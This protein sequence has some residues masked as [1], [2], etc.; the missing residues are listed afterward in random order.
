MRKI[1]I[2]VVLLLLTLFFTQSSVFAE[3]TDPYE[4][5][6]TPQTATQV[7]FPLDTNVKIDTA[8]DVDWFK[9][10][11]DREGALRFR[12][13]RP[14]YFYLYYDIYSEEE[15][16]KA[17]PTPLYSA[18]SG[19]SGSLQY[20]AKLAAGVY[21]LKLSRTDFS[22]DIMHLTMDLLPEDECENNDS[23]EQAYLFPLGEERAITINAA[24]EGNSEEYS[25]VDW[26]KVVLDRKG[27]LK[28]SI[29]N[30]V[31]IYLN[32]DIYPEEE[33]TK[34]N[35]IPIYSRYK[36]WAEPLHYNAKL[37]AG[38][39][40]LKLSSS[41]FKEEEMQLTLDLLPEDE[42]EN[43]DS[44]E[45]AY[46]F[47]LGEERAITINADS[48]DDSD[49]SN[50][51]DWFKVVLN[52]DGALKT[53]IENSQATYIDYDI[54]TEEELI[55]ENP[56]PIYTRSKPWPEPLHYNAKLKSGVY[57]LKLSSMSFNEKEMLL[58]ID[59]LAE[60]ECENNDSWQ[61]AYPFPLGETKL[62]T[63]N[64]DSEDDSDI[65]N[66]VD[67]FK[68]ELDRTGALSFSLGK[69][70]YYYDLNYEVY[71]DEELAKENPTPIYTKSDWD[72]SFYNNVK[73][74]SGVYY[75]KISS[76]DLIKDELQLTLDLLPEDECE[77]NDTW[78][79]AYP[80]PLGEERV[81]TINSENDTDWFM[82]SL[83]AYAPVRFKLENSG[84]TYIYLSYAI[85]DSQP[86]VNTTPIYQEDFSLS[87]NYNRL[88]SYAL[89]AGTYYIKLNSRNEDFSEDNLKLTIYSGDINVA[90]PQIDS[91]RPGDGWNNV[92]VFSNIEII[93]SKPI[94]QDTLNYEN[95]SLL[96][97]NDPVDFTIDYIEEENKLVLLPNE[98]LNYECQYNIILKDGIRAADNGFTL[99]K[100]Y[101]SSFNTR[102][103]RI[104]DE[105]NSSISGEVAVANNFAELLISA[106]VAARHRATNYTYYTGVDHYG[107]FAF[108]Y[109]PAGTYDVSLELPT[110]IKESQEVEIAA[111]AEV[112]LEF[113]PVFGDFNEDSI[114][115][116]YDLVYVSQF[117]S[118]EEN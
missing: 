24:S 11:L 86:D 15:V 18:R 43:N 91:I 74:E 114:V 1:S 100:D 69:L 79:N 27:A 110:F 47:P 35:P 93:F 102:E 12:I 68:V 9:V 40:Y 94:Q 65:Y 70:N 76:Q 33:L 4:N 106:E 84:S 115:D 72:T 48:E 63:I 56:T 39:Y 8:N 50:D 34:E 92:D 90:R 25:D 109:L 99:V 89:E 5:N 87:G 71:T 52:R 97:W 10:V 42:C 13:E 6:D 78:Q 7:V 32:Y 22:E 54:Y 16:I 103:K 113:D 116:L 111:F 2:I 73:L 55:K 26:F 57:Y 105:H 21:Y 46:L 45:N 44:W 98:R 118:S 23:W 95:I 60:D 31:Y 53:T 37:E 51:V 107:R 77:D 66:D 61:N 96:L 112:S 88:I 104:D 81:I 82:V 75:L 36:S 30:S 38:V 3:G 41:S 62:I 14:G 49:K 101:L 67:W 117:Y 17:N 64:A 108:T 29:E 83:D 19:H 58:T 20:N 85:F 28:A 80:F 59:L